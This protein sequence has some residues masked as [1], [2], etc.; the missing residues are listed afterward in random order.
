AIEGL[1]PICIFP[2]WNFLLLAADQLV[3]HLDKMYEISAG[4]YDP[5]VIIRVMTPSC[6]PFDP[7]PQHNADYF[8]IFNQLLPSI[9]VIELSGPAIIRR[10]YED[11]LTGSG[12]TLLIEHAALYNVIP[13][14]VKEGA[15]T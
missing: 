6:H 4:G 8:G 13:S 3:N 14:G 9:N 1:T 10:E 12:S 7:G 5:K 2:R 15:M 11:A